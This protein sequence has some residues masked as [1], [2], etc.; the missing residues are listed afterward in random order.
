MESNGNN[1]LVLEKIYKSYPVS[2]LSPPLQV[3]KGINLAVKEGDTIGIIGQSGSGKS[4]LLN[5]IGTLDKPDSGR[6]LLDGMD[7]NTLSE[8][9]LAKIRNRKIGFV[10][11][12]HHLLPQCSAYENVM[13][14]VI[15]TR[16]K[17][18]IERSSERAVQLLKRVGLENRIY[19]KPA[20]LSGG[21]RQRVAVV[22]ALINN[23]R[24]LLADEPTGALDQ[25]SA[26]GLA[27]L[28]VELNKQEN[29]TLIIATHWLELA[30]RMKRIYSL[31]DG[32]LFP[33]N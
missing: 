20:E 6:I 3:L 1:V 25:S 17:D 28:L 7:I 27:D 32:N 2:R 18:Y 10:F 29:V 21:E 23:P 12:F 30:Q 9:E 26:V 11:Q 31:R 24:L 4:T 22:R 33:Q 19:H 16:D 13:L 5:L 14:P 8:T 15:A